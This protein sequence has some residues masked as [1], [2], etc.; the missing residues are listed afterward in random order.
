MSDLVSVI[1]TTYKRTPEIVIRAIKS[2]C[3][4]TYSDIEIIVVDDSP[5]T[6]EHRLVLQ[7]QIKKF[8]D[9]VKYIAHQR[10]LG[11]CVARNTGLKSANGS[12]V[13]FLDDD[14][15]WMPEKIA[16]QKL[17]FN[18]DKIALVYCGRLI[19]DDSTGE[20]R[21]EKTVIHSGYVYDKLIYRNFI[22]PTSS[23]LIKKDYLLKIGGFDSLMNSAQD[24]DVWLRLARIY[25]IV[26]IN[27]ILVKYHIHKGER[28]SSNHIARI[29]GQERLIYKNMG[30]LLQNTEA[31][32]WRLIRLALQYSQNTQ[33]LKAIK[34]LIKGYIKNISTVFPNLRYI[35]YVFYYYLRSKY[36]INKYGK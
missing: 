7:E 31:W 18:D 16:K 36:L 30:Y 25:K 27:D 6:Y 15:E 21:C 12:Y 28:I 4:Q 13:A 10:N 33:L 11:A 34:V 23:P 22:G 20:E 32:Q 35:L 14:D 26:G 2:V 3:S 1:I 19:I 29:T 9:K 8:G 24:Y 5:S 17:R